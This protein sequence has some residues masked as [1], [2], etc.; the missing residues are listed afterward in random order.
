MKL[1]LVAALA[2]LVVGCPRP[3]EPPLDPEDP[4]A[5]CSTACANMREM[6]C[7]GWLQ[8]P[9]GSYCEDVCENTAK[10]GGVAWP[11]SCLSSAKSCDAANR[12]R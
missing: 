4:N 9:K 5:T 12:C 10:A 6:G 11:V 8:T 3:P 1:S 2:L 7:A